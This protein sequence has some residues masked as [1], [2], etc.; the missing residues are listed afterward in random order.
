M[1]T[2]RMK[3]AMRK[4]R[5]GNLATL[6]VSAHQADKMPEPRVRLGR[7]REQKRRAVRK[8]QRAARRIAQKA[9]R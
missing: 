3:R 9:N 8:A 4:G 1:I 6:P 2:T 5:I 7:L